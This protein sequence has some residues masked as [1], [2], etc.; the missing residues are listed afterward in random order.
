MPVL[1]ELTAA[2]FQVDAQLTVSAA[3]AM[4]NQTHPVP[5]PRHWLISR[6]ADF[7]FASGGASF[8]LLAALALIVLHG[9]R[10]I[11]WP[12][13][14]LSELHLG[15]TYDAIARRRLWR[16]LPIDVLVVPP[17]I[18]AATYVLA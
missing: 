10:E 13:L 14:V 18:L 1:H 5:K 3:R 6:R 15:A 8:G 17:A 4:P 7:W 9:D 12:D 16:R 2:T 11:D